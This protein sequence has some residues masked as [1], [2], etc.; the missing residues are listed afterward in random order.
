MQRGHGVI[1]QFSFN[2]LPKICDD[3]SCCATCSNIL[4]CSR[5]FVACES[6]PVIPPLHDDL[7][8]KMVIPL[9]VH[10]IFIYAFV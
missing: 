9:C 10:I 2:D 4:G 8:W 3:I 5:V 6:V 1:A 7:S